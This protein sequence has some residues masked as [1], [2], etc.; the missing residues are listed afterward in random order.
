MERDERYTRRANR[1]RHC[2][3]RVKAKYEKTKKR[4]ALRCLGA[5]VVLFIAVERL[6]RQSGVRRSLVIVGWPRPLDF[7]QQFRA[8]SL[9]LR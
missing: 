2:D 7:T 8:L 6:L 1:I 4:I 5:I 3:T 9:A